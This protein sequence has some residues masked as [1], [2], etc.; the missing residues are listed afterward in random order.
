MAASTLPSLESR[1]SEEGNI[2]WVR[3]ELPGAGWGWFS[4]GVDGGDVGVSGVGGWG[5]GDSGVWETASWP[6]SIRS[7]P[8]LGC[9]LSTVTTEPMLTEEGEVPWPR[10]IAA[11]E[12]AA[13]GPTTVDP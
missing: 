1:E 13:D 3:G 10:P 7:I 5:V 6:V 2:G 11:P 9:S 12:S 8:R 4:S